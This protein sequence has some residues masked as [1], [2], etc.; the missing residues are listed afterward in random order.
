MA[1]SEKLA[2]LCGRTRYSLLR[3]LYSPD[4][5][6][7]QAVLQGFSSVGIAD[8]NSFYGL[9]KFFQACK[10][11]SV[12]PLVGVRLW[13]NGKEK[14]VLFCL[15]RFGYRRA[16]LIVSR[17]L[18]AEAE[19]PFAVPTAPGLVQE[20]YDPVKDLSENGWE[21]LVVASDDPVVL[22]LL[23]SRSTRNLKA[24][25]WYGRPFSSLTRLCR[26]LSIRPLALYDSAY[27]C[28]EQKKL[29]PLL[30]SID[31]IVPVHK[32][33]E[34]EVLLPEIPGPT[35]QPWSLFIPPFLKHLQRPRLSSGNRI[36]Q[37]SLTGPLSFR[38][39]KD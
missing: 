21:G 34:A 39:L 3:G 23:A 24:A 14:A 2:P 19:Y 16:A 32:L 13:R 29:Y 36:W 27:D 9:V 30:R 26:T 25:L 17:I 8:I 35:R 38:P 12:K 37:T 4:E 11:R 1:G 33:P 10:K 15:D 7:E 6:V 5:Y 20:N 31:L 18:C 22:N 28:V